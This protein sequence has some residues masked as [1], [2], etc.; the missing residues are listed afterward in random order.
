MKTTV[1]NA[2]V[3]LSARRLDSW[4]FLSPGASAS[5]RVAAARVKGNTIATLGG[6]GGLAKV[7]APNRFKRAYAAS[8]E[9]KVPYLRPYDVFEF[10]PEAADYLSATRTES[11][12][13]YRLKRGMILQ[14]CSGRNLGPAVMVDSYL[15]RYVLSHD[16]VRIEIA[17]EVLRFFVLAFLQSPVGQQLLRRDKSGSVIDHISDTHV[18]SLEVPVPPIGDGKKIAAAMR[19]AVELREEARLVLDR[20]FSQYADCLPKPKLADTPKRVWAVQAR[21]IAGRLDAAFYA[22]I[23]EEIRASLLKI[24]GVPL[25]AVAIVLKPGGRNKMRYV[26]KE[27]GRPLLSGAQLLQATPINLRYLAPGALGDATRYELHTGWVA[28]QADGRSEEALGRPVM[29]T[30]D[31][32]GWLASGHIGRLVPR[33]PKDAGWLYMAAKTWHVQRQIKARASGSVVDST[34]PADMAEVIVPPAGNLD[35]RAVCKAW[36]LFADAKQMENKACACVEA[37]LA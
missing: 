5:L 33:N 11:L 2:G 12:D 24:G 34:F 22:P 14:S 25:S 20:L 23:V 35:G 26:D 37:C 29:V 4:Y 31:R 6:P 3:L 13:T 7:W 30:K 1:L 36:D 9:A 16:M 18:A 8:K 10:L 19:R 32:Q 28:Y 27:H 17:D 21:Q 15:E